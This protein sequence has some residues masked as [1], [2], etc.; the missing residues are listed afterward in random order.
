M[1][2]PPLLKYWRAQRGMSQLDLALIAEVSSK[3]VSFLETG[4]SSPTEDM[5]LKLAGALKL[6]LREQ[7][8]LLVSAGFHAYFEEP[9]LDDEVHAP[10]KGALARML[11]KHDPFPMTVMNRHFDVVDLNLGAKAVFGAVAKDLSAVRQPLNIFHVCFDEN[12]VRGAI[13]DWEQTAHSLLTH[14]HLLALEHKGDEGLRQLIDELLDYPEVPSNFRQPDFSKRPSPTLAFRLRMGETELSFLS[15][16][17]RFSSP[18]NITLEELCIESYY[19]LDDVTEA[20]CNDLVTPL[21]A[22]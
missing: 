20:A 8:A 3:H 19:P 9:N 11:T 2:F 6:P 10:I 15:T 12:A 18:G 22:E 17:T 14:L 1:K 13:V 4:R 16:I 21:L 7:N 5:V